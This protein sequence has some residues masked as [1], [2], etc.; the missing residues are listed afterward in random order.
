MANTQIIEINGVKVEVDLREARTIDTLK[1]GDKI[2]LLKKTY[3]GHDVHAGVI[4]GFEPF[5]DQPAIIVAYV[6][7]SYGSVDLKVETITASTKDVQIIKS[8]DDVPFNRGDALNLFEK[9]I[10]AKQ[11]EIEDIRAKMEYFDRNF[12]VYWQSVVPVASAS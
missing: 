1:V 5:P 12:G 3:S 8:V 6:Q 2:K 10:T 7:M 11:L 9:Q 4:V